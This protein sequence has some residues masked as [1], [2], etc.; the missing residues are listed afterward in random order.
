ME[1]ISA[2]SP[3]AWSTAFNAKVLNT[4]L[5][6]QLLSP[7]ATEF[8]S[9][10]LLLT[11]SIIPSLRPP[12]YAVESTVAAALDAFT[13]TL[14][15]E[16]GPQNVP[17]C[18]IK[19]G[20]IEPPGNKHRK[21]DKRLIKGTSMRS[22]HDCVFDALH[23]KKPAQTWRVGRGALIYDVIGAWMPS[24]LIAR[25][26]GTQSAPAVNDAS[27]QESDEEVTVRSIEWEKVEQS[28]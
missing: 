6:A 23:A 5:T 28:E 24:T 26:M 20:N 25:M 18:H 2:I 27:A 21:D 8:K 16:L 1:P 22:L 19:L 7:L 15:A 9:R 10:V 14:A 12:H 4:I 3:E 13:A 11:P 17:V